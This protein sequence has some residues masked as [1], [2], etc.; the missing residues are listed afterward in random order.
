MTL[1][2]FLAY[3]AYGFVCGEALGYFSFRAR[4][5]ALTV[6]FMV[7]LLCGAAALLV[8][9]R[10]PL[11]FAHIFA[12]C[13]FCSLALFLVYPYSNTPIIGKVEYWAV[14]GISAFAFLPAVL[15]ELMARVIFRK[16][17]AP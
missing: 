13:G 15:V 7:P 10:R 5:E 11:R 3:A 2:E 17:S 4:A 1:F 16:G 9:A 14:V 6:Y 8:A 12:S